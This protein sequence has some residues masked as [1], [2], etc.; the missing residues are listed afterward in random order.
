MSKTV[1]VILDGC[2]YALAKENCGYLEHMA[3]CGQAA[4]YK[5]N[6][7]LPSMS[8]PLYATLLSGLPVHRHGIVNNMVT[9]PLQAQNIFSLCQNA[10]LTTAAAAYHWMCELFVRTPFAPVQDRFILNSD[11]AIQNGIYYFEDDYPDSHLFADA[12]F[13]T[14]YCKPDFLLV[15]SMNI[16]DQGHKHCGGSRQQA[17]AALKADVILSSAIPHWQQQGYNIVVTA[18]HGMNENGLHGGNSPLQREVPLYL[19]GSG[20]A[21]HGRKDPAISQLAIAPLLCR[22]LG[23]LPAPDMQTF[24]EL[25]VDFF[26]KA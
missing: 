1:L 18:D 20:I 25:E 3:E 7:E 15:H 10:G 8:R 26:D 17:A 19:F 23:I 2:G 9:C 4:K 5:V 21:L 13:L 14:E 11:A 12:L 16:D 22:L 6:S 24:E